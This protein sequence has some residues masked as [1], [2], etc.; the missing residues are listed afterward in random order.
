MNLNSVAVLTGDIVRSG[1]L[2]KGEILKVQSHLKSS[3]PDLQALSKSSVIG[4][5]G[6][7]RGDGWQLALSRPDKALRSALYLRASLKAEFSVDTRVCIGVGRV[8]HLVK[9]NIVESTG[10]AF[11]LSGRA[12]DRLP[13]ELFMELQTDPLDKGLQRM[14]RLMDCVVQRWSS[15]E[16]WAVAGSLLG[17]TQ[18]EIAADRPPNPK[19]G[20]PVSRQSISKALIRSHWDTVS[21]CIIYVENSLCNL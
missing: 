11:E 13:H 19:T 5:V 15:T 14:V 20:N 9:E 12:L 2:K 6:I 17:K 21:E 7:T 8:D 10:T 4:H 1:K 3:L 16:A 18:E